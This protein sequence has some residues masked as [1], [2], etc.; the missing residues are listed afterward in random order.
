MKALELKQ[1]LQPRE[2]EGPARTQRV[3]LRRPKSEFGAS[4]FSTYLG[5]YVVPNRDYAYEGLSCIE[6]GEPWKLLDG[7]ALSA[8]GK[9][10]EPLQL[11]AKSVTVWPWKAVYTYSLPTNPAARL[12]VDYYLFR[13]E[14]PLLCLSLQIEHAPQLSVRVKP[15]VDIRHVF[16]PSAWKEHSVKEVLN[17]LVIERLGRKV[18]VHSPNS[19]A[20]HAEPK[21][22]H[23]NYK[24]GSGERVNSGG[25]VEFKGEERT[26]CDAGFLEVAVSEGVHT[27]VFV[28]CDGSK[29]LLGVRKSDERSETLRADRL[30]HLFRQ[31]LA[32]AGHAWGPAGGKAL[33]A[34][35]LVLA[36]KFRV[37]HPAIGEGFDAGAYW[38]RNPW[39]S[40]T[41]ETMWQN[42]DFL[43]EWDKRRLKRELVT[44]LSLHEDGWT[45]K[46]LPTK[47][48]APLEFRS[49]DGTL[50]AWLL[51]LRLLKK[52]KDRALTELVGEGLEGLFESLEDNGRARLNSDKL[53]LCPAG[54]SWLDAKVWREG[55]QVP[56]RLPKE[57]VH[58]VF[59][60][61]HSLEKRAK[62]METPCLLAEVNAW[63]LVL[64]QEAQ[65]MREGASE[66]LARAERAYRKVFYEEKEGIIRHTVIPNFGHSKE[67]SSVGVE[68]AALLP[69]LFVNGEMQKIL[70]TARERLLVQRKGKPFGILV[71]ELPERVFY[72]DEQYHGAV[73]WPRETPYLIALARKV[74]DKSLVESLLLSNLAHQQEEGCVFYSSELLSPDH[75]E[76]VPVK[77]PAQLWS[78]WVQPYLEYLV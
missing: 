50:K 45:P 39:L 63:W 2:G 53:L 33:A 16:E 47:Q 44:W 76:P 19:R 36:E 65:E 37:S 15:L 22:Q 42:F 40:D 64:L 58:K 11:Q 75:G 69:S 20:C 12:H 49:L 4:A 38:F 1:E 66:M 13:K 54:D 30:L 72:N 55:V 9:N 32:K 23:W 35:M 34:R 71:R 6:S 60:E 73:V 56:A 59:T 3:L 48:G 29:R 17:G 7:I 24:L 67:A 74:G 5:E 25:R 52:Q 46:S 61:E 27:H 70:Q 18:S 26:V 8:R 31:P 68:A 28:S 51:A 43:W 62:R 57:F 10:G 21:P 78:S 14:G 41:T 77:N